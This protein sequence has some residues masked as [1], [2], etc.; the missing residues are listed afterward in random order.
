MLLFNSR[1]TSQE[2]V[3]HNPLHIKSMVRFTLLKPQNG[4]F[5]FCVHACTTTFGYFKTKGS[6]M[7]KVL[8]ITKGYGLWS[9]TVKGQ[10]AS[11]PALCF[12]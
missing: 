8:V 5:V 12:A 9:T 2:A 7:F 4:A 1:R 11:A 6:Y 10:N 3:L